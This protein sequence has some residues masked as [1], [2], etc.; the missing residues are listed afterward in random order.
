M[1]AEEVYFRAGV[2]ML[3]VDMDGLV[4]AAERS[5]L[6][7]AW[8]APQGGLQSGEDPID[9]VRRELAEETGIQWSDVSIIA[10]YPEWLAYELPPDARS[11]KTGRGQVHKWFLL[12]H[13]G[14]NIDLDLF[15]Q[16]HP[17]F[18]RWTWMPIHEL[19]ERAWEV[20]RPI[21]IRLAETWVDVLGRGPRTME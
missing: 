5:G 9:A 7:G 2:G 19:V 20:R 14:A 16:L 3:V 15:S 8:Q 21:Y 17:E 10:E 11:E 6:P 13:H 12:R 1:M 4:L 18:D